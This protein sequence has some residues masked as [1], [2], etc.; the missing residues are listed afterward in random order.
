MKLELNKT[1][2]NKLINTSLNLINLLYSTFPCGLL[3][4]LMANKKTSKLVYDFE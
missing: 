4:N 3:D 2:D 1:L